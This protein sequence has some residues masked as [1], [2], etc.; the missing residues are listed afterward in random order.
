VAGPHHVRPA[1]SARRRTASTHTWNRPT[2]TFPQCVTG[3]D[4]AT[5]P[6]DQLRAFYAAIRVVAAMF[7]VWRDR[8][9]RRSAL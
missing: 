3:S 6:V 1:R 2:P 4:S 9:D 5:K 8:L 7:A